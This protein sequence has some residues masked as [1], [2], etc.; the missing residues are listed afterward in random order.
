MSHV[1]EDGVLNE[2]GVANTVDALE[3][4]ALLARG[5]GVQTIHAVG[6]PHFANQVMPPP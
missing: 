1:D 2:Y 5:F 4:F 6:T 3:D